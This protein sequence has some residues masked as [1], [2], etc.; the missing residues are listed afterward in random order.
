MK[1]LISSLLLFFTVNAQNIW[2]VDANATGSN[3]GRSWTDAWNYF[4]SSSWAGN[5]GINWDIIQPGDTIY[6]SGGSDSTLYTAPG[7]TSTIWIRPDV[8]YTFASGDPVVI[9]NA[10]QTG[11][12]GNV[13]LGARSSGQ[14]W[15]FRMMGVSNVELNGLTFI[16]NAGSLDAL[17]QIGGGDLGDVDSLQFLKDC[18]VISPGQTEG[19][20][21]SG[22]KI[23]IENCVIEILENSLGNSQDPVGISTGRGGHTFNNNLIVY[24]NDNTTTQAHRDIL[25]WS[26]FGIPARNETVVNTISN[27]VIIDTKAQGTSWTGLIYSSL[28]STNTRW[29]IYNN[30]IVTAKN[31]TA[32]GGII[33]NNP[34]STHTQ[35]IYI[36]NNTILMGGD[37]LQ[38]PIVFSGYS[39]SVV[40]KNNL[41]VLDGAVG[42]IVNNQA[43][44]PPTEYY[45]DFNYNGYYEYGGISGNFSSG[46]GFGGYTYTEWQAVGMDLNSTTGDAA[47]VTFVQRYSEE[48]TDYYTT[49]GRDAGTDLSAQ[50]PFLQYDIL[51]NER[52]GSWDMGALEFV[53]TPPSGVNVKSK[54]F[55]QGP[56]NTN[57]MSTTLT[58]S[59]LL[60]NSQPYN[61]PPWNYNGNES[62]TSGPNSTMV[63]WV[64]VELRSASNPSQVVARRAAV[65]KNNGLLLETNGSEGV[66]FNNV[67][68][69]SYY[70]A[71]YHR[72]HLAIMSAAP[73]QLSSNSALY[74][75][76]TAMNKAYGQNPMVEL[77]SG[78]YGMYASD[79][80]ADGVVNTFDRDNVWLVQNGNMGYLEGDFNMNSGV[81]VHDV[82]QLWNINNGKTS[83]VP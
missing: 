2:Y 60:P 1:V 11:H 22:S 37:N 43:D 81:T 78:K 51:G 35:D 14:S 52:T 82:N 8:Y 46:D 74:D 29:L 45:R 57:S 39:D 53:G 55:L 77:V 28:P 31:A 44:Y 75:F 36:L 72:N 61:A 25:Q 79:G 71:I 49:T 18:H 30:I 65:L 47:N 17:I 59:S 26:N 9:A 5:G 67:N 40:V 13:Y 10:Y 27:N 80:N 83:Q 62:F 16:H 48:A 21:L 3:T 54:I 20:Y 56:F 50:F 66:V 24:R 23:T 63:D 76:T 32:V 41:V 68:P 33:L 12:S 15:I 4:D 38:C 7:S 42:V 19:L 34:D 70:I 58:Q 64:L 6:V 73:V 69:G